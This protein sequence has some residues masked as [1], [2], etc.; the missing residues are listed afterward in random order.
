MPEPVVPATSPCGPCALSLR[1]RK[2]VPPLDI[3]IGAAIDFVTSKY[4]HLLFKL[5]SVTSNIFK[6]SN[7]LIFFC[8]VCSSDIPC[9]YTGARNC[10]IFSASWSAI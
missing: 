1:S 3:P 6:S 9:V 10:A 7:K 8:N 4:S 5:I 2:T